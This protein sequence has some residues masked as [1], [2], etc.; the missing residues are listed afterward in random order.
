MKNSQPL[1]DAEAEDRS[2]RFFILGKITPVRLAL[3]A[4]R[5]VTGGQVPDPTEPGGFRWSHEHWTRIEQSEEVE[6]VDRETF[7]EAVK[8]YLARRP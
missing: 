6:E 3:D 5:F 4:R 2:F 7:E 1:P 8:R